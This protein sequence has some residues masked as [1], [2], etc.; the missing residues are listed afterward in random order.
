MERSKIPTAIFFH[1]PVFYCW[2]LEGA[3]GISLHLPSHLSHDRLEERR[4]I[5]DHE[6]DERVI[7]GE[8]RSV[9]RVF[10]LLDLK[11]EMEDELTP[12]FLLRITITK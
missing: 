2:N 10:N 12:R 4:I 11:D 8:I 5:P 6:R 1:N 9:F 7:G 3:L